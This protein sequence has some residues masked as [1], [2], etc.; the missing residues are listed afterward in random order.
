MM[1]RRSVPPPPTAFGPQQGTLQRKPGP[2]Q[3]PARKPPG[4]APP[5]TRFGPQGMAAQRQRAGADEIV[6]PPPPAPLRASPQTTAQ[7]KRPGSDGR[8]DRIVPPPPLAPLRAS[9]QAAAQAKR[10][11]TPAA[12]TMPSRPAAVVQK[13]GEYKAP[14]ETVTSGRSKRALRAPSKFLLGPTGYDSD[15][16]DEM[17]AD[18]DE[19]YVDE[20]VDSGTVDD[21]SDDYKP[22]PADELPGDFSLP[23]ETELWPYRRPAW[24]A[25]T[26]MALA[27]K[28]DSAKGLICA[29]CD[30][31]IEV[32]ASG[33]EEWRSKG[34]TKKA[35]RPPIDHFNPD[36]VVRLAGLKLQIGAM[37]SR[38]KDKAIRDMVVALFH[39]PD[40]RITHLLCNSARPKSFA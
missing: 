23:G 17:M 16:N 22:D 6:P 11:G 28:Q 38:P 4:A 39:K 9:P 21:P 37:P 29:V 35:T 19:D 13:A 7:A 24:K 8:S 40:L 31:V 33:K 1:S 34:G 3:P 14:A 20:E 10:P 12:P 25:G 26:Y 15:A 30:E 18:E 27:A 32:N 5:P 2:A 36:W